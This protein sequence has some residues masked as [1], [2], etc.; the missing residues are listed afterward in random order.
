MKISEFEIAGASYEE[1]DRVILRVEIDIPE[2]Y[3]GEEPISPGL[4]Q[5]WREHDVHEAARDQ[6][7]DEVL[8]EL[9]EQ[10]PV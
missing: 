8:S 3:D 4:V 1:G 6:L 5:M 2:G 7:R 10:L 9:R